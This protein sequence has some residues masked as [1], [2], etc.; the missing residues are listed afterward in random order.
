SQLTLAAYK[1][2]DKEFLTMPHYIDVPNGV[3]HFRRDKNVYTAPFNQYISPLDV[4]LYFNASHHQFWNSESTTTFGMSLS[5]IFSLGKLKNISATLSLN[6]IKYQETD[7]NQAY[8]SFSIPLES[9]GSVSYDMQYAD[10][11]KS[12]G[13]SVAYYSENLNNNYWSVRVGGDKRE[14]GRMEPNLSGSYQYSSPY[15]VLN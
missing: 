1:F 9:G 14:L 2:S 15:G 4:T 8:L 13:Q 6:K 3:L 11:G 7:D 10:G 12:L 5:K